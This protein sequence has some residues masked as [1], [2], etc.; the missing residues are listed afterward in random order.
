M[1]NSTTIRTNIPMC[2]FHTEKNGVKL[3]E[4]PIQ[5]NLLRWLRDPCV[6]GYVSSFL[7]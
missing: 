4:S 3:K 5:H 6:D 1:R 7:D 2:K